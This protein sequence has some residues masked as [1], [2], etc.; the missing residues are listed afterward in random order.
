MTDDE[1]A[2]VIAGV[3]IALERRIR[4]ELEQVYAAID[5][6][7]DELPELYRPVETLRE[8][9][10]ATIEVMDGTDQAIIAKVLE[11]VEQMGTGE[12]EDTP[13]G[14]VGEASGAWER[15]VR[16]EATRLGITH[17]S[18]DYTASASGIVEPPVVKGR[19]KGKAETD[20]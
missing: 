2:Q 20:G 8:E 9:F 16:A 6:V 12:G 18:L 7:R 17:P 14:I 5:R 10:R 1:I 3:D 13:S 4:T 19:T 11:I 15:F